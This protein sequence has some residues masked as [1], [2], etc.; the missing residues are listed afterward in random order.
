[1]VVC[2]LS[3]IDAFFIIIRSIRVIIKMEA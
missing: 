2:V 1:M 3:S